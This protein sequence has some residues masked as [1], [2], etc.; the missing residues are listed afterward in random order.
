MPELLPHWDSSDVESLRRFASVRLVALDL[1]GTTISNIDDGLFATIRHLQNSLRQH[2][3]GVD[4][5]IATGRTYSG[6]APLLEQ[7][8]LSRGT[9]LI[10]YNGSLVLRHA[11]LVAVSAKHIAHGDVCAIIDLCQRYDVQVFSYSFRD[12]HGLVFTNAARMETVTAWSDGPRPTSDFNG[13]PIEWRPDWSVRESDTSIAM[14]VNVLRIPTLSEEL[15][16]RLDELRSIST[17]QSTTSF[18]EIRPSGSNKGVALAEVAELVGVSRNQVLAL[19]DNDNDVEMLRWAG[20]GIAVAG[21][22][23]VARH[24]SEFTCRHGVSQ[25]AV[26]VLRLIKHARRFFPPDNADVSTEPVDGL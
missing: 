7:W 1:D 12:P 8:R 24:A 14:L 19:G 20:I 11:T 18:L 2:R 25:A 9:P 5:T 26:E 21:A 16:S 10:L 15:R 23:E 4:V 17:T 22:S 13:M 6:V 3:C